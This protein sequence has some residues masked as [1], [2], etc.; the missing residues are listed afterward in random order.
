LGCTPLSSLQSKSWVFSEAISPSFHPQS[1]INWV[2]DTSPSRIRAGGG[3]LTLS[4]SGHRPP[5]LR[6]ATLHS[7]C[8]EPPLQSTTHLQ[9]PRGRL[10][11]R[12]YH[13]RHSSPIAHPP[14]GGDHLER[15]THI[16]ARGRPIQR[17]AHSQTHITRSVDLHSRT[18]SLSRSS[19]AQ[20]LSLTSACSST[21]LW[22]NMHMPSCSKCDTLLPAVYTCPSLPH[23]CSAR[24]RTTRVVDVVG[25]M[26]SVAAS[27]HKPVHAK[28]SPGG[29]VTPSVRGRPVGTTQ[30]CTS[31]LC[32]RLLRKVATSSP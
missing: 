26:K 3:G 5:A 22:S 10:L 9:L 24:R 8:V 15:S 28:I 32:D 11:S 6:W 27:H 14:C 13:I 20:S 12:T 31:R 4:G 18:L 21:H 25:A 19:L 17:S 23:V 30:A 16:S 1:V 2:M 29:F 7:R